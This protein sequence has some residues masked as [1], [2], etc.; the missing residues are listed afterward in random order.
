MSNSDLAPILPD[1]I[2]ARVIGLGV[3]TASIFLAGE[4]FVDCARVTIDSCVPVLLQCTLSSYLVKN[5]IYRARDRVKY[6]PSQGR[7]DIDVPLSTEIFQSFR[8]VR[9][10][11][12]SCNKSQ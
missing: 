6:P 5:P 1:K 8:V 7:A 11:P 9:Q 3:T 4:M 12:Q 10:L 2:Q